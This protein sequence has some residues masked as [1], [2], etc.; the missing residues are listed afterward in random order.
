MH[1]TI[2]FLRLMGAI[3]NMGAMYNMEIVVL[4]SSEEDIPFAVQRLN[5]DESVGFFGGGSRKRSDY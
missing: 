5:F 4:V 1:C 3:C 2:G